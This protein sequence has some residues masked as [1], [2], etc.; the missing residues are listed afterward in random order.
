VDKLL[1]IGID[2]LAGGNLAHTLSDRCEVVGVSQQAGFEL[3]SCRSVCVDPDEVDELAEIVAA[4]LPRLTVYCG[5]SCASGWEVNRTV[6]AEL[7]AARG[8]AVEEAAVKCGSRITLVSTD[9]VFAGP[10]LFHHE[11]FPTADNSAAAQAARNVEQAL[12]AADTLIL[13]THLFGWSTA[14]TS[15]AE[16]MW[17]ELA[18]GREPIVSGTSY[19]TPILASDA[20]EFVWQA[21]RRKL[22]GLYHLGGAERVNQWQF[23]AALGRACGIAISKARSA[24]ATNN[25][26]T[27]DETSLDSRRLQRALSMPLPLVQEGIDRFI[28]QQ[29]SGYRQRLQRAMVPKMPELTAA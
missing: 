22:T 2:T 17:T 19:A 18:D 26:L 15:Y 4:E 14:G 27:G 24:A 29:D 10:R 3:D 5:P 8:K 12:T 23:A 13:R 20:A 21:Y 11:T 1:V 16:R 9:A 7:E 28:R 25:L 6:D